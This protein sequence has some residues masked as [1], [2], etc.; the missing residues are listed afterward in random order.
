MDGKD[1]GTRVSSDV[2][3]DTH[4]DGHRSTTIRTFGMRRTSTCP[5]DTPWSAARSRSAP[6][7][8]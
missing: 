5:V 4:D 2:P 8:A 3:P 1:D 7:G 6:H